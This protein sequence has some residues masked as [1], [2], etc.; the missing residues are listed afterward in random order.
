LVADAGKLAAPAPAV[1]AQDASF[2][3][4]L[5]PAQSAQP[6]VAVEL[7]KLAAALS[8]EQSCAEP[9]ALAA[10]M[11]LETLAGVQ[12]LEPAVRQMQWPTAQPGLEAEVAQPQPRPVLQDEVQPQAAQPVSSLVLPKQTEQLASPP[13]AQLLRVAEQAL[14]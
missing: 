13:R 5:P 14:V 4:A 12:F 3:S 1:P 7:Y 11:V 8:A 9:V 6:D 10:P 2:L